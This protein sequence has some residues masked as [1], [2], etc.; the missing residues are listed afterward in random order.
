MRWPWQ[1]SPREEA[2]LKAAE[3]AEKAAQRL[4]AALDHDKAKQAHGERLRAAFD[5]FLPGGR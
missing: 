2:A 4:M 5:D 1:R 3:D